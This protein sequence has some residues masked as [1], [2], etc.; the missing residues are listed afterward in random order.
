MN[1]RTCPRCG[2]PLGA[3]ALEGM[4]PKC[5]VAD[6]SS[7]NTTVEAAVGHANRLAR[8]RAGE[9]PPIRATPPV[10]AE[11]SRTPRPRRDD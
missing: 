6:G 5:L 9:A 2:T 8:G 7:A 11:S 10:T 3:G 1:A 4:C